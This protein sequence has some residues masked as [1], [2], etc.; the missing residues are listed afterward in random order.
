MQ[1]QVFSVV[2]KVQ[3]RI[4]IHARY[5]IGVAFAYEQSEIEA[6]LLTTPRASRRDP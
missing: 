5:P 2:H 6:L 4:Q 3:V 1:F